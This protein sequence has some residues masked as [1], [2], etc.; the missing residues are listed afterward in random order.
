MMTFLSVT[1]CD[2]SIGDRHPLYSVKLRLRL[3]A[4]MAKQPLPTILMA[5]S[6]RHPATP[7]QDFFR[8][9]CVQGKSVM[10]RTATSVA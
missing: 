9:F 10:R 1:E 6:R 3:P 7:R 8:L 5:K 4:R 2:I